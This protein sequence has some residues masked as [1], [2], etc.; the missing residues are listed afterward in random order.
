MPEQE[1]ESTPSLEWCENKNH[2]HGAVAESLICGLR[3]RNKLLQGEFARLKRDAE[4]GQAVAAVANRHGWDGMNNSK[5]LSV[6]I[7]GE[8]KRLEQF[9]ARFEGPVGSQQIEDWFRQGELAVQGQD[10]DDYH[11]VPCPHP[12]HS[13]AEHW[14]RRGYAHYSRIR[15]ALRA[16]RSVPGNET[17]RVEALLKRNGELEAAIAAY[18]AQRTSDIGE[19]IRLREELAGAKQSAA[20]QHEDDTRV[21]SE[22]CDFAWQ[23]V[24]GP[25]RTDWEY[26]AQAFRH[27]RDYAE[28]QKQ[29]AESWHAMSAQMQE[30][31][32][33]AQAVA[34]QYLNVLRRIAGCYE[35]VFKGELSGFISAVGDVVNLSQQM[36]AVAILNGKPEQARWTMPSSQQGVDALRLL[37][38]IETAINQLSPPNFKGNSEVVSLLEKV[39]WLIGKYRKWRN[40]KLDEPVND[41]K[42]LVE[43]LHWELVLTEVHDVEKG[44]GFVL[45]SPFFT[46]REDAE[47]ELEWQT[48]TLRRMAC[49]GHQGRMIRDLAIGHGWDNNSEIRS[50]STFIAQKLE[51]LAVLQKKIDQSIPMLL[52]CPNCGNQHID[53]PQPERGWDNPLHRSHECQYCIGSDGKP[54]VWR[55]CDYNTVGVAEI[56]SVGER[57]SSPKPKS[58][59]ALPKREHTR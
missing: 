34:V 16:E 37:S 17:E 12:E 55:V 5:I 19:Q 13:V 28:E 21:L 43:K 38:D 50:L 35:Q 14:W 41:G 6:F 27:L 48:R 10:D 23:A 54:Y 32:A 1:I 30:D 45:Q 59:M 29:Q 15:R 2:S 26:P 11:P 7:E 46:S 20:D 51:T 18:A 39:Y 9:D 25:D 44:A 33:A 8:L 31:C 3:Q 47:A 24:Y 42:G 52:F 58:Q 56:E 53:E 4:Q 57:D 40:A 22:W 36:P 49:F